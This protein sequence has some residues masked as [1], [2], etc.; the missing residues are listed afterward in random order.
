[1]RETCGCLAR[2]GVVAMAGLA[3]CLTAAVP[4][5]AQRAEPEFNPIEPPMQQYGDYMAGH[6]ITLSSNYLGEFAANPAGGARQGAEFTGEFNLGADFD[7]A[8]LL[9]MSG[10]TVHV[11]FTDR[12][13]NN[14]AAKSI[15]NSISVQQK[16]G[17]GQTYQLTILSWEQELFNNRLD[18]KAG[19]L[20]ISEDFTG[21]P[22]YCYFQSF[23]VCSNPNL[24]EQD[25][26]VGASFYPLSVWGANARFNP[27]P[28]FY[29]KTGIYQNAPEQ[30]P[31]NGHG[32][33]WSISG[34]DGFQLPVEVGYAH[35]PP[36]AIAPDQY[37]VGIIIDRA[38]YS[39][40]FYSATSPNRYGRSSVYIQA[41]KMLYQVEPNSPRGLYGFTFIGFGISGREQTSNYSIEAGLL[42]QGPCASRPLDTIGLVVSD[43]HYNNNYLNFLYAMRVANGGTEFPNHNLIMMELNYAAQVTPWL[44]MM[45]NF[46]YIVNPDGLGTL[47]YPNRNEKNAVVLGLQFQVDF[48]RLVGLGN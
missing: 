38:H 7:L 44:I 35:T 37:D 25:V 23:A 26:F 14:L 11:L 30:D 16:Y 48:A 18:I 34:S 22:F 19:R 43:L 31:H 29:I 15:N 24:I 20:D 33:N 17:D 10:S 39:A 47:G 36:G 4:A 5:H 3:A 42:D 40:P 46:Q 27:V 2:A 12:A 13:G 32:F 45:P 9:G 6:G 41:Q 28:D 21:S 1:M 8:K